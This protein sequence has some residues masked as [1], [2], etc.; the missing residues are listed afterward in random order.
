MRACT[1]ALSGLR[2]FA[3]MLLGNLQQPRPSW[4]ATAQ[5]AGRGQG[6]VE[7]AITGPRRP[8][9]GATSAPPPAGGSSVTLQTS[10][11]RRLPSRKAEWAGKIL[12]GGR[13][14]PPGVDLKAMANRA[15]TLTQR[16]RP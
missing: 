14:A 13:T 5:V 4:A 12:L 7:V 15:A 8:P 1:P 10:P 6:R 3:G 9:A 2:M 16:P 11:P